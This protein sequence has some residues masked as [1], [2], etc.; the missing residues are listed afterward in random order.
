MITQFE[1]HCI[2]EYF[3]TQVRC[4]NGLAI[5]DAV[6]FFGLKSSNALLYDK[7][8]QRYIPNKA[9][10]ASID[11]FSHRVSIL[12]LA[13]SAPSGASHDRRTI[14]KHRDFLEDLGLWK[15]YSQKHPERNSPCCLFARVDLKKC[16][17]VAQ[18]LYAKFFVLREEAVVNGRRN[19]LLMPDHHFAVL[20]VVYRSVLSL[21]FSPERLNTIEDLSCSTEVREVTAIANRERWYA[22]LIRAR[23]CAIADIQQCIRLGIEVTSRMWD[24]LFEMSDSLER[25]GPLF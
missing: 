4:L 15:I 17:I 6:L 23:D 2:H 7:E 1:Q 18:W 11:K 13:E 25:A 12:Y 8:T 20:Q 3:N 5:I 16:L 14:R 21:S 22:G 10:L 9:K 19:I 24:E